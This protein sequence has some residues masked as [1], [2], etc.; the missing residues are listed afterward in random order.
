MSKAYHLIQRFS[1]DLDFKI[2]NSGGLTVGQ[3]RAILHAFRDLIGGIDGLSIIN[4]ETANEGKK[5][6][7]DVKYPRQ[8]SIPENL[9]QSLQ[10]ELF[11]DEDEVETEDRE[12][13]SFIS[14]YT[15]EKEAVKIRCNKPINIAADKFNAITWRIY[16]EGEAIDYTL[17]RHLHDLYAITAHA[18][19]MRVFRERVLHN[20]KTKDSTRIKE[21]VSFKGIIQTTLDKL[22]RSRAYRDGYTK[23]VDSMSYAPDAER[24]SF[25]EALECFRKLSSQF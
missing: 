16:Q 2:H 11:F 17:M 9:R 6:A 15:D 22:E 3:R 10:I 13:S 25:D 21:G 12:V 8:F 23:F 7:I 4:I 5:E 24:I 18:K 20:F 14:D 1:E 19:D